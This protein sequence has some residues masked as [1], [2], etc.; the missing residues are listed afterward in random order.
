M[1]KDSGL[2]GTTDESSLRD[3]PCQLFISQ[4]GKPWPREVGTQHRGSGQQC[5][6]QRKAVLVGSSGLFPPQ[7]ICMVRMKL[8]V[9]TI[10]SAFINWQ[11]RHSEFLLKSKHT[12]C[13]L[14]FFQ[15]HSFHSTFYTSSLPTEIGLCLLVWQLWRPGRPELLVPHPVP[16]TSNGA[17]KHEA[18][19]TDL[20]HGE[21]I[22][23]FNVCLEEKPNRHGIPESAAWYLLQYICRVNKRL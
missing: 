23:T 18:I 9:Q 20:L 16:S 17:R 14:Q 21:W 22:C 15:I 11:S 1:R 12:G 7:L 10:Y 19:R 2:L 6:F 13:R 8:C 5:W 3:N 4:L